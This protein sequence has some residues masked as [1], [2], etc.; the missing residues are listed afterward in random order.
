[1][2]KGSAK[3]PPKARPSAKGKA[4]R[5]SASTAS[6]D[7]GVESASNASAAPPAH[8]PKSAAPASPGSERSGTKQTYLQLGPTGKWTGALVKR[9]EDDASDKTL[10]DAPLIAAA[11]ANEQSEARALM[12]SQASSS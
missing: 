8:P 11:L 1:M 7:E 10:K 4:R 5:A 12:A 9:E 2:A 6:A 3:A